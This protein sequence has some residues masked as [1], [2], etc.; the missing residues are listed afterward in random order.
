MSDYNY[1][2]RKDQPVRPFHKH[3]QFCVG[4]GH[5]ALALRADYVRQLKYIHDNLGIRYVRFHGILNDDMH[6]LDTFD[7][8]LEGLPCGREIVEENFYLCG[9]AYD[10]ILSCGMKP[11]VELSFMPY[12][13]AGEEKKGKGFYGSNFGNPADLG[14]WAAY[15]QSFVRYLIHRYGEKEVESWYFEVWNEPDLQ[16]AFYLGTQEDYFKLYVMTATA[17]KEVDSRLRVGGPAT[18][19]SKWIADFVKFTQKENVPVDFISTHQYAGDPLTGVEEDSDLKSKKTHKPDKKKQMK[20]MME[21][22]SSVLQEKEGITCLEAVRMMFGD[23]SEIKDIP[24]DRF[25]INSEIVRKQACGL[26]VIYDEWNFLATFSAESN[27]TRKAAAY[28]IRT[29]INVEPNVTGSSIWCFSDIFEEMH[30]FKEEFHGGFGMLTIHGIPKPTFHVFQMLAQAG[31]EIYIM[32]NE[33]AREIEMSAFTGEDGKDIFFYRFSMKQ[34]D[35]PKQTAGLQFEL[36][37]EPKEVWVQ[38]IDEEHCNPYGLW[39][40]AGRPADLTPREVAD[41]IERSALQK[42]RLDYKYENGV[43][44]CEV[45]LGVNDICRIHIN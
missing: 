23:P 42:E 18:S 8:I 6:T 2:I 20:E 28:D 24:S 32:E 17:V 33:E 36:D 41:I 25:A 16:G 3:W 38:R 26:P 11:F 29:A 5:A 13:L 40:A 14:R 12:L 9:V 37:E 43:L 10:N 44:S 45:S 39:A 30:Q 22:I 15:I 1:L 35:A 27:D 34:T 4:S 21:K 31:D 19:G 7:D